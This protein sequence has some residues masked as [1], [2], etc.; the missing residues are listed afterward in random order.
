MSHRILLRIFQHCYDESFHACKQRKTPHFTQAHQLG[1]KPSVLIQALSSCP[2]GLTEVLPK[3]PEPGSSV[4]VQ[5]SMCVPGSHPDLL[6][7]KQSKAQ[8]CEF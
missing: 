3:S 6:S 4:V 8:Q 2:I 7:Q 1:N 5:N